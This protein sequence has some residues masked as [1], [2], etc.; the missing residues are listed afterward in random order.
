MR[1]ETKSF[2]MSHLIKHENLTF[3]KLFKTMQNKVE[4]DYAKLSLDELDS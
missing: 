1:N 4:T 2:L 3:Q